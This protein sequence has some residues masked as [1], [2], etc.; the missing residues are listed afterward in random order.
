LLHIVP[1]G[2]YGYRF[3]YG[4][5]GVHPF[6]AWNGE[7]PGTLPMM[8]GT[9]EAPSGIVA[10]ESDGLPPEYR[11]K[12]L[13]T[14]WGDHVVEQFQP[15]PRGASFTAEART[16]LRGGEDFRPVGI[17]LAPDGSL[18]LSDWVDKSYPVHGKG[19]VWRVRMKKPVG[20]SL[21]PE[22]VAGLEVKQLRELLHHPRVE[23]RRAA[24][25]AL[26]R[27]KDEAVKVFA[28]VIREEPD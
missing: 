25:N 13:V 11:G 26:A 18:V 17:A 22:K 27:K 23:L 20:D 16:L 1:G 2:D 10:Y 15:V 21:S 28:D 14:S 8:A 3:R 9:A 7:L 4:R 12:L 6:Q 24:A 19:R 5:K